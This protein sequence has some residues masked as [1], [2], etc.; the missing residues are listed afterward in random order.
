[1][2]DWKA[3]Q[4]TTYSTATKKTQE[5]SDVIINSKLTRPELESLSMIISL[6]IMH[7][8]ERRK[9]R[10]VIQ[11]QD[12][13]EQQHQGQERRSAAEQREGANSESSERPGKSI[14]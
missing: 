6:E 11:I 10:K 7:R 9:T 5:L 2:T 12:Y 8:K 14:S 3:I 4:A 13:Q 1:M